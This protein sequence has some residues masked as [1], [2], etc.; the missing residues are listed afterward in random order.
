[1]SGMTEFE[2]DMYE[3]AK[4]VYGLS[5]KY[6]DRYISARRSV[7][8]RF[9]SASWQ[10]RD[11]SDNMVASVDYYADIKDSEYPKRSGISKAMYSLAKKVYLLSQKY[12]DIYISTCRC[13]D[14]R[15]SWT[16]YRLPGE[17]I[18]DVDYWHCEENKE[19]AV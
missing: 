3:L 2:K 7:G 18:K 11:A 9:S 13:A 1:M 8:F 17:D 15:L 6:G 14:S 19:E 10:A 12:G 5:I 16:S 4:Y